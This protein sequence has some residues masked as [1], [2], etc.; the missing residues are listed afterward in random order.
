[1]SDYKSK[2][3][4]VYLTASYLPMENL[5]VFGTVSFNKA[6]ASLEEVVMPDVE[7]RLEGDLEDQD[8][9]FEEMPTY[10]D[11]D[12]EY[13]NYQLG[14][15]YELTPEV[16]WITDGSFANLWDYA[17]YIYGDES[18]SLFFVRSGFKIDF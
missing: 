13:L 1:M 12:F 11:L 3:H 8:F 17:P 2:V 7:D 16:T 6:Q 9:T 18:G 14:F 4:N 10:S 5:R 15:E